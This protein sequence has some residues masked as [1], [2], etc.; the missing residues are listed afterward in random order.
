MWWSTPESYSWLVDWSTGPIYK[1]YGLNT[2][3]VTSAVSSPFNL[4]IIPLMEVVAFYVTAGKSLSSSPCSQ[5]VMCLLRYLPFCDKIIKPPCHT[6]FLIHSGEGGEKKKCTTQSY[7]SPVSVSNTHPF[8]YWIQLK[9]SGEMNESHVNNNR[10]RIF[11]LTELSACHVHADA[12]SIFQQMTW[13]CRFTPFVWCT[14][15]MFHIN[16]LAW[17]GG[18]KMPLWP[19]DALTAQERK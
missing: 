8:Q 11:L 16:T 13:K 6:S 14:T 1:V 9:T 19:S 12:L 17:A 4:W 2:D 10:A 5:H 18:W 3:P 7:R 15:A